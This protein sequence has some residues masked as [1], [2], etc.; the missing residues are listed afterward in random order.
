MNKKKRKLKLNNNSK[1][2]QKKRKLDVSPLIKTISNK[3]I[4]IRY[5]RKYIYNFMSI[6]T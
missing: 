6:P 5:K 4:K 2:A 1:R 3:V